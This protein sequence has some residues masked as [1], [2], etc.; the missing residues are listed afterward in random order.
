MVV[1]DSKGDGGQEEHSGGSGD[2]VRSGRD[3]QG[4]RNYDLNYNTGDE[5][6]IEERKSETYKNT[7]L[8]KNLAHYPT[9]SVD[10]GESLGAWQ[11][12]VR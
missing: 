1:D 9:C 3:K 12:R 8:E 5:L 6:G 11:Q 10:V 2:D 7:H 4:V